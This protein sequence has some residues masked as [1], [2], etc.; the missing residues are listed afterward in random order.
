MRSHIK[1]HLA[2]FST[3]LFF[4]INYSGV[5]Y[6]TLHEIAGPFGINILRVVGCVILFWILF[7]FRKEK[8]KIERRDLIKL[9]VCAFA[10][11][12]ANQMLFIKG[13]ALSSP[14]Q[15]SLLALISPILITIFASIVLKEKLTSLKIIGLLLALGGALLLLSGKEP[16]HPG[17]NYL[18]GNLLVI[19]SAVAYAYY[20][21]IV[22]PLMEKYSP[23]MVTRWIFTFGLL[24]IWPFCITELSDINFASLYINDWLILMAIIVPGTFLA[25][26]FNVYGIK[27]LNASTA[28][29]Y[30]YT[31]P[32]LAG[33]IAAIF[34]GEKIT[35][36]KIF[37][38]VLIFSGLYLAQRSNQKN[39]DA[40]SI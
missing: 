28:G 14:L 35:L 40:K 9:A 39:I 6:F 29:A 5:K 19:A 15:S 4:A 7:F 37:A 24:M 34:L 17:D 11:I 27:V 38:A 31:Q 18:L 8:S 13:L 26:I 30:I 22:K 32:L 21:I 33:A 2:L 3:N 16:S 20:F 23:I 12:A 25:Y 10:A 1:A 36:S